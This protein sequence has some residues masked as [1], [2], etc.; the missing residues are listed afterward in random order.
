MTERG[1]DGG[2]PFQTPREVQRVADVVVQDG[3]L[4]EQISCCSVV[5][6]R[7]LDMAEGH[8]R[9]RR[10]PADAASPGHGQALLDQRAS[11]G[12]FAEVQDGSTQP[13]EVFG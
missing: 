11:A 2:E 4:G 13:A 10:A 9:H 8:Q 5:A 3:R 1:G 12:E 7:H 6:R